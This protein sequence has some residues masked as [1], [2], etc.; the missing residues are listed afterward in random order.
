VRRAYYHCGGCGHG[1]CPVDARL[2]LGPARTT[3]TVQA[4]L[5]VLSTLEP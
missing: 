4:R 3:P 2:A 5:A 1:Y